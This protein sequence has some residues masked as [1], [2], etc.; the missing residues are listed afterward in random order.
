[1]AGLLDSASEYERS[2]SSRNPKIGGSAP[3]MNFPELAL[4]VFDLR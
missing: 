4:A 1:M 3:A 2:V